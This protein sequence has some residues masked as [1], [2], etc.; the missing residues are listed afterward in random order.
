MSDIE[1]SGTRMKGSPGRSAPR[2]RSDTPKARKQ[3]PRLLNESIVAAGGFRICCDSAKTDFMPFYV[4]TASRDS[5][6]LEVI[7]ILQNHAL[8]LALASNC[9]HWT[10]AG[11]IKGPCQPS[12]VV[13]S[14]NSKSHFHLVCW[15]PL[16][17]RD[18]HW[19]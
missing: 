7:K 13:T 1:V 18:F 15:I 5:P 3:K 11:A 17:V 12:R 8:A 19:D 10:L 16:G 2:T 9:H 4:A 6:L 14:I